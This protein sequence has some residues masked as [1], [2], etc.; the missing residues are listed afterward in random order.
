MGR[1]RTGWDGPVVGPAC[2]GCLYVGYL[3]SQSAHAGRPDFCDYI[4]KTGHS[5][6]CPAGP[7]CAA[8]QEN[9]S[10]RRRAAG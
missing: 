4:G 10:K 6:P 5:R 7:G 1:Q 9:R 3:C 8:R 2:A